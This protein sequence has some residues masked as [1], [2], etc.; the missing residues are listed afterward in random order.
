MLGIAIIFSAF[1]AI[2]GVTAT[3]AIYTG[4][5]SGELDKK[6][7]KP[8]EKTLQNLSSSL[9]ATPSAKPPYSINISTSY[10]NA[11]SEAKVK[12]NNNISGEKNSQPAQIYYP[13][14]NSNI[15]NG[16]TYDQIKAEQDAAY[17]KAKAESDR[18][19]EEQKK[20]NEE[21]YKNQNTINSQKSQDWYNQKTAEGEKWLQEQTQ[22]AFPQ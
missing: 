13:P 11:T 4:T 18:W 12:I 6:V 15:Y 3:A 21:W 7:V 1:I 17:Q 9:F 2:I 10:S 20:K 22:K 5:K 16:K 14:G 8:L 19:F